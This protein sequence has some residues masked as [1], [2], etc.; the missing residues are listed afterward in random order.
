MTSLERCVA[1][2]QFK[3]ADRVPCVPIIC[4]A[5][6]RVYG[7]NYAE[8]CQDEE[9][10]AKAW[11]QAQEMFGFDAFVTLVDLSLEAADFGQEVIYPME[12]TPHPNYDNPIITSPDDFVTKVKPIDF[13]K[14]PRMQKN[15]KMHEILM[16][17]KGSSVAVVGFVF[18]PLG[19]LSMMR[20]AEK[21]F[22]DCVKH[23]KEVIAAERVITDVL[24]EYI[25]A[26]CKCGCHS[27]MLDTL[28]ASGSIMSKKLWKEIEGPF[29]KELADTIRECGK[30]VSVHNCGNNV[31][32]DAQIEAM[33]PSFLSYAYLPDDCK[34]W[35]EVK[36]K[37]ATGPWVPGKNTCLVGHLS[38]AT[39]LFLGNPD[40][41]KAE[42]KIEIAD[43]AKGGGYILA[44]GC[45]F[46]PNGSFI[47]LMALM[48][49]AELY[50]RY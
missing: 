25:R 45:E 37:Y 22:V 12:D 46:P 43:M 10:C 31:Y 2:I 32:L 49:A 15:V 38:P 9:L 16:N 24:K 42:V 14:A 5:A 35:P 17:E 48:E 7:I 44:P 28:F 6:R 20:G 39:H 50:G 36:A 1:A 18:G 8:W 13:S 29:A 40:E 26:L 34:T 11:I 33:E 3:E 21:L 30:L 47:N 41:I 23:K 19:I 4:G 27:I